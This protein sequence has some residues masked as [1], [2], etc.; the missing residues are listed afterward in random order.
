MLAV[1]MPGSDAA[2]PVPPLA[3]GARAATIGNVDTAAVGAMLL[4]LSQR[5]LCRASAPLGNLQPAGMA[6]HA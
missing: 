4:A 6:L 5:V 3:S 2:G 1:P